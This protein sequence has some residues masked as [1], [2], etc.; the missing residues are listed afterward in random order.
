MRISFLIHNGDAIGGTVRTTYNLARALA[1]RHEVEVVSVFRR[2][3]RPVFDP[4]S[5]V[6]LRH[7]VDLR[8]ESPDRATD[9]PEHTRSSQIFA[10]DDHKYPQYSALTDRLIGEYLDGSEADVVIGTRPGLN[11]HIARQAR[12]GAIRVGQEHLTLSHHSAELKRTL[13]SLYPR[14]DAITT[15][16]GADADDYRSRLR[17][18]GVEVH[19]LP[20]SVPE[21]EVAPSGGGS[22]WVVAA[23]RLAPAKRYDMLIRAFAEVV[24]ERPDWGLRI[25]GV[26]REHGK[27][28]RTIEQK[29]LYNHVFLM[30][31]AHPIDPEWVKGS[32][33]AV[34]SS[35]ESFGMTIVEA[36]RCGLPV[37]ATDCP[38]GPA[39]IIQHGHDGWLVPSGDRG[40]VADALLR[41]IN[42]D[43][44]RRRM[45]Q[46]ALAD[47]ARFDPSRVGARY[48]TLLEE[49]VARRGRALHHA[50]GALLGGA[51]AVTGTVKDAVKGTGYAL[52][53]GRTA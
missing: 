42:D 8:P 45:G 15:V 43:A 20:N 27:L 41:L 7:L 35:L 16:T 17:L 24:A 32:I 26:G 5:G 47:A 37:V 12:L 39:E 46:A 14:L 52:Q 53:G 30:G 3:D 22:K 23:G 33:G 25:Y 28:R 21:P 6:R 36:M 38:H 4:G 29:E 48:E 10:Q 19:A 2:R 9:G 13:R 34:T 49:L 50:R 44:L 18:P 51:Y 11:V 40:A 31:A 1:E